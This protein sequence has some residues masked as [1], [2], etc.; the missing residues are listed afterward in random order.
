VD[1]AAKQAALLDQQ[2]GDD[3]TIARALEFVPHLVQRPV[4]AAG[5]RHR[6]GVVIVG[7][8]VTC[9]LRSIRRCIP[10][11]SQG[12]RSP[13]TAPAEEDD[14]R[15]VVTARKDW[16]AGRDSRAAFGCE[17]FATRSVARNPRPL[18]SKSDPTPRRNG[19]LA[20][21][22]CRERQSAAHSGI[23]DGPGVVGGPIRP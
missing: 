23:V 3:G 5:K 19:D 4:S 12:G 15:T 2:L 7:V 18:G 10:D 8:I 13:H 17:G 14:P 11:R 20:W 16:H 22:P 9:P 21:R 6:L 1:E